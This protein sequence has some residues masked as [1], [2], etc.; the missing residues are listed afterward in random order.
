MQ[1]AF[2]QIGGNRLSTWMFYVNLTSFLK[3]QIKINLNSF[4]K[5]LGEPEIGGKQY[6]NIFSF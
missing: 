2:A 3:T 4:I 5:K 1:D 6:K